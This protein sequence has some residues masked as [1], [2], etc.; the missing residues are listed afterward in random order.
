MLN[1]D[2]LIVREED[3]EEIYRGYVANFSYCE[4]DRERTVKQFGLATDIFKKNERDK[5]MR[6][7][8]GIVIPADG[9]TDFRF[10]DLE[11]LIYTRIIL[12]KKIR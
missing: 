12:D 7:R 11:F 3:G 2:R 1:S 4:T 5:R 10:S 9:T 6:E 8:E